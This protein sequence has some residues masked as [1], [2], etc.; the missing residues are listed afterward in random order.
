MSCH[1][2]VSGHA[3][4]C[5][6]ILSH[7]VSTNASISILATFGSFPSNRD[8]VVNS[9]FPVEFNANV[10]AVKYIIPPYRET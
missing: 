7:A 5:K 3:F 8:F 6:S 4:K 10:V 2:K 1:S 9:F